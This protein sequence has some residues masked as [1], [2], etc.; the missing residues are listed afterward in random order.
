MLF[1]SDRVISDD[2]LPFDIEVV[3]CYEH[4]SLQ[5]ADKSAEN[6]AAENKATAGRGLE[7]MAVEQSASAGASSD[8]KV[9]ESSAY[10][11]LVNRKTKEDLGTF[12]LS[13]AA[14]RSPTG[15]FIDLDAAVTVDGQDYD[16]TLRFERNYKPYTIRL[17]DVRKDDYVGTSTPRNYSSTIHLQDTSR[18]V[19]RENITISMN[20]PLR[21]ANETFYQSGYNIFRGREIT[22]LQ[23][24]RNSGWMI[25]YVACMIVATG[26]LA[27]F[28]VDRK[29]TR[30]NSSHT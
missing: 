7:V 23:I 28:G 12:L 29:S 26:M 5:P 19:D 25:P 14:Y 8:S 22:T 2:K 10:V 18:E 11:K 20:N 13:Q 17:H 21:Y 30:L 16:L 27:H 9:D 4:S 3:A 24:V 15:G 1:R 6:K